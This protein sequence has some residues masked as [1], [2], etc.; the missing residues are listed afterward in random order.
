MICRT[1]A[2]AEAAALGGLEVH[3]GWIEISVSALATLVAAFLGSWA[4]FKLEDRAR[5]RQTT[6]DQVAAINRAQF[7]LIAQLNKLKNIQAHM[8][9]RHRED[10]GRCVNMRPS[11][12]FAEATAPV[13][14]Q[15]LSF[16]LET[17]DRNLVFDIL[18][19]RRRYS[20][21]LQVVDERSDLHVREVQPRLAAA[22]VREGADGSR[23]SLERILGEHLLLRL[24]RITE[25]TISA[26]DQT[27]VSTHDLVERFYAAMKTRYPD[28]VIIG[29][30]P[31]R[32]P[33]LPLQPTS[34]AGSGGEAG[35]ARG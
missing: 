30:D 31:N 16:L 24:E 1:R 32:P 6:R 17:E 2:A 27:L 22:G 34:G 20:V 19:E 26:V 23:A 25:A 4:A 18:L 28:A 12:P 15:E 9:D 3:L 11:L 13:D 33:N 5:T 35:A 21:A 7:E 29:L 10:P 14:I 8:V